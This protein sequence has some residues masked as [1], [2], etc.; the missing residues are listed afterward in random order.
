[1]HRAGARAVYVAS[2]PGVHSHPS[3]ELAVT[4]VVPGCDAVALLGAAIQNAVS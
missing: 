2:E 4:Y 3:G 1:L